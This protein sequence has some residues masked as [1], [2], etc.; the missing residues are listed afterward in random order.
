MQDALRGLAVQEGFSVNRLGGIYRNGGE[1]GHA[2]KLEVASAIVLQH[3]KSGGERPNTSA[4]MR[5]CK[6]SREFANKIEKELREDGRATTPNK[7]SPNHGS[8]GHGSRSLDD[9]DIFILFKLYMELP[10]RGL[11]SY[12]SQLEYF[13]GTVVSQS[14][15]CRFF[16]EAF[17]YS[18]ALHR[19]NLVPHDKFRPENFM[20]AVEYLNIIAKVDPYRLKFGDEKCLKGQEVYNRKVRRHPFTGQ[21][22]HLL[23]NSDF[24]NT[25]S[26]TGFC[27][28]DRRSSAVFCSTH[29]D[30][31]DATEFSVQLEKAIAR[32][33]FHHGDILVLDNA[34][35]H[36][37]KEN[38]VLE[39][40]MWDSFGVLILFLPPRS[41]EL[42]PIELV[43]NILVQRLRLV[44]LEELRAIGSHSTAIKANQILSNITHRE[45]DRCYSKCNI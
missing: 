20:T 1:Y 30:T 10:S 43:W 11:R 14:T 25:Y 2:K 15:L 21:V 5:Q 13:T 33:Y 31:N 4:V 38:S 34:Q 17:P 39:E 18:A 3:A 44:P 26:L 16:L 40:W 45:V 8:V 24:R 12:A 19:P 22:P 27:G 35:I 36:I 29:D 9:S 23:T 32:G 41:P 42:N 28:I 7:N 37:G 6:V